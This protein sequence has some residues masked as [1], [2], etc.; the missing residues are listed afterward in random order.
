MLCIIL[1]KKSQKVSKI[2]FFNFHYNIN[3]F[4]KINIY[5]FIKMNH[6]Q[7]E[8]Q[9]CHKMKYLFIFLHFYLDRKSVV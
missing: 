8:L 7:Y 3:T 2:H 5:I 6:I 1:I 9:Q 4:G